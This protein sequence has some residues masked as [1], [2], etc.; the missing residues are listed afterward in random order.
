MFIICDDCNDYLAPSA[1]TLFQPLSLNLLW[2]LSSIPDLRPNPVCGLGAS[3][4]SQAS[5][6]DLVPQLGT[7]SVL[8]PYFVP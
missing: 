7:G 2:G 4:E 1:P 6:S 5:F 8:L 3:Q